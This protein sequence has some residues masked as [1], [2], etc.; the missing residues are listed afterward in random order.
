MEEHIPKNLIK[1]RYLSVGFCFRYGC[2]SQNGVF[3]HFS[4]SD[5]Y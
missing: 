5:P 1:T 2:F 4:N 3:Y